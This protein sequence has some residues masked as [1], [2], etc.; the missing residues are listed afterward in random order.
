MV[1]AGAAPALHGARLL[2]I[3]AAAVALALAT[4]AVYTWP[5]TVQ[6]FPTYAVTYSKG[7]WQGFELE[8]VNET[9]HPVHFCATLYGWL[10]NGSFVRIGWGCGR[11]S[12]GLDPGPLRRYAEAWRDYRGVEPGVI[13]LL[14]Y[15][16]GTDHRGR[17]TLAR[18][19]KSFT[20]QPERV[21]RGESVR[22]RVVVRGSPPREGG[23]A[24]AAVMV[25]S[26]WP[27]GRIMDPRDCIPLSYDALYCYEWW[28]D[29]V[30]YSALDTRV[31][32]VA[33][34]IKTA[35]EAYKVSI[36]VLT[37]GV[38]ATTSA[39]VYFSASAAISGS[40]ASVS[41][42]Q[43]IYAVVLSNSKIKNDTSTWQL[44]IF[45]PRRL[46]PGVYVVGFY[47]DVAMARYKEYV[48]VYFAGGAYDYYETGYVADM[49]LARP[50][51][52]RMQRGVLALFEGVDWG[53]TDDYS[54]SRMFNLIESKWNY[55]TQSNPVA[56]NI[57]SWVAAS[58]VSGKLE[59]S[60]GVPLLPGLTITNVNVNLA[61]SVG[62]ELKEYA[63]AYV[64][65]ALYDD[66]RYYYRIY[67][68]YY[69][70]NATFE[71]Q[72]GYYRIPSIF[73]DISVS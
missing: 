28:L 5:V 72:G 30:N 26:G 3:A 20:V 36:V 21:L 65:A 48:V 18:A 8:V 39:A 60:I 47:G 4:W 24:P 34:R 1:R 31:P 41:Y 68:R 32:T 22:A 50:S 54:Y 23:G 17:P 33:A 61:F 57:N 7:L 11:G 71:F 38:D 15:V 40:G 52:S 67:G 62:S 13:V 46:G 66:Y 70:P 63:Y 35:S 6:Y 55:N 27:P 37:F 64:V 25:Q 10:P 58:E 44:G 56:V 59:I 49:Y 51:A 16:N 45:E 69:Y 42:S 53:P 73:V 9:G 12:K 29:A 43:D 2:A 14:T 19:A